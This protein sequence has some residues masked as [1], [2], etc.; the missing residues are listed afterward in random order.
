MPSIVEVLHQ[1][2]SNRVETYWDPYWVR[3]G[4]AVTA[5]FLQ[6]ELG[7]LAGHIFLSLTGTRA[8]QSD[9]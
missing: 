1:A 7:A 8:G 5:G 9:D 4:S 6:L 3:F 2:N